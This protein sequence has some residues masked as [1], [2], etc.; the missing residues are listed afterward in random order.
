[1][2]ERFFTTKGMF[3]EWRRPRGRIG[4]REG[5]RIQQFNDKG[6][7]GNRKR[8]RKRAGCLRNAV[9]Q[10]G[11]P[12]GQYVSEP[13]AIVGKKGKIPSGLFYAPRR[14]TLAIRE[15][16]AKFGLG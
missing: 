2:P 1:M 11:I 7:D 9:S 5:L 16:V 14:I 10:A 13:D 8:Q 15:S 12:R 3:L 4:N 6:N